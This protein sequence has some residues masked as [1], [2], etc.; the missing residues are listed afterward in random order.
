MEWLKG[1]FKKSALKRVMRWANRVGAVVTVSSAAWGPGVEHW[2]II[3]ARNVWYK[4]E[5]MGADM[6]LIGDG[7]DTE[8]AAERLI[9]KAER[10]GW[11]KIDSPGIGFRIEGVDI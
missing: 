11:V 6:L 8:E 9:A 3:S 10:A 1:W 4:G 2:V 7:K 5:F